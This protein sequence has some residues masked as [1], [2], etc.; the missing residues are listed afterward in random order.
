M[1][2]F[3]P[4]HPIP[5]PCKPMCAESAQDLRT[6]LCRGDLN[7]DM[8]TPVPGAPPLLLRVDR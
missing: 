1:K 8:E 5:Q 3:T 7:A 6:R 2:T 4:K